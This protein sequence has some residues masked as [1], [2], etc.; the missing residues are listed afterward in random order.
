[1]RILTALAGLRAVAELG[2]PTEGHDYTQRSHMRAR[3]AG[4]L[5]PA[6][7]AISER[8]ADG[9]RH[10]LDLR[11]PRRP[12]ERVTR[13]LRVLALG[14]HV[15]DVEIGCGATLL[16]LA[17]Y[18]G[19]EIHVRVFS[20]H[21]AVPQRQDRAAEGELAARRM[22]YASFAIFQ[23]EDTNFPAEA[24][25]IQ[26]RVAGL[27]ENLTPDLVLSPSEGDTH[28]D[29]TTLAEA[30]QREFRYGE[31]IWCYE[32]NQFGADAGF[33]PNLYVNVGLPSRSHDRRF[34]DRAASDARLGALRLENT[35]AHEKM[36]ILDATMVSQRGKPL[37][38]PEIASATMLMRGMQASRGI[39][40]AEAFQ[41]RTIVHL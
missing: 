13:P 2:T 18:H 15:D 19:A 37:L 1:M 33:R 3:R 23:H 14:P 32:I 25:Q 26:K 30:A 20:D 16:R 38:D 29:H 35:L 40:F 27:R 34:L 41:T 5:H 4:L 10:A 11:V 36:E 22:G 39:R 24:R 21:Y 12:G 7:Q 9:A 31:S 8:D 28:Q 17:R 6:R